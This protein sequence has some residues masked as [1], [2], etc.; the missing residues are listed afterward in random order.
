MHFERFVYPSSPAPL[1]EA[2]DGHFEAAFIVLHPF[3]RMPEAHAWKNTRQYPSDGDILTRG[4]RCSWAEVAAATGLRS[5]ARMNQALLTSIGAL[6]D[7]LSDDAARNVLQT[8]LESSPVWMPTEGRFEPLLRKSLLAA[9]EIARP[10]EEIVF[11][12][13]F[14]NVDPIQRL[15][16]ADLKIGSIPFPEQGSLV[17]PDA[18]L[19]LTV[20]WESFFTLLYGK[21]SII[22]DLVRR[23]NIEG[24]FA[25]PTT[26]HAWFNYTMGCATVTL[27][28]E[29]WPAAVQ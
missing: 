19:L 9:F 6:V 1:I 13:E 3:I 25:T 23:E 26:E 16:L 2:Y 21:K 11:V 4:S 15:S 22:A 8:F 12:P 7:Y 28:P 20:D 29:D 5:C 18:S 24:F 10:H 17:A 14:P 27:S